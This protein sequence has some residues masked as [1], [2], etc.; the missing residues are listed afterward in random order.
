[1][2]PALLVFILNFLQVWNLRI[3][4]IIMQNLVVAAFGKENKPRSVEPKGGLIC[5]LFS[6]LSAVPS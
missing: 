6:L 3:P 4:S 1:M 2:T 5:S